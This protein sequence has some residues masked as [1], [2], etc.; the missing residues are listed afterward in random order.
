VLAKKKLP[1][2][3]FQFVV[4]EEESKKFPFLIKK[5]I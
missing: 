4:E 5:S 1:A 3:Q 2:E